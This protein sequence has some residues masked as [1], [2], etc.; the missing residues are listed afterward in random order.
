M[1]VAVREERKN[2]HEG[3]LSPFLKW[4]QQPS[5]CQYLLFQSVAHRTEGPK[6]ERCPLWTGTPLTPAQKHSVP[7]GGTSG[8]ACVTVRRPSD[9]F[10]H[11]SA[12]PDQ[13][14][15]HLITDEKLETW[16][17]GGPG[18]DSLFPGLP[19]RPTDQK[20]ALVLVSSSR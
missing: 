8:S 19:S 20:G 12:G 1:P 5:G 13:P 16:R 3:N 7:Q 14:I 6:V 15:L 2:V 17:V 18:R 4:Q 10:P 9:T 11:P